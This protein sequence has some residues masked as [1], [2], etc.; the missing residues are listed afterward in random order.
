MRK[1]LKCSR[2][3]LLIDNHMLDVCKIAA[4]FNGILEVGGE[5]VVL[6]SSQHSPSIRNAGNKPREME[7]DFWKNQMR[8]NFQFCLRLA[9]L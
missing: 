9:E 7:C 5:K 6:F 1:R 4:Q 3:V 2:P 8:E